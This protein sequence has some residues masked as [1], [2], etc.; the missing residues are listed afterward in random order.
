ME[1]GLRGKDADYADEEVGIAEPF[2]SLYQFTRLQWN[3]DYAEKTRMKKW[4]LPSHFFLFVR[5]IR[6]K[7]A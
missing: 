3:A 4:A 7:S 1:R 2:L 5:E 6:V